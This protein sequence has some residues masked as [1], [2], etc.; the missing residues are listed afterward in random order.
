M[1]YKKSG[2]GKE[3]W[4]KLT[5]AQQD[6]FVRQKELEKSKVYEALELNWYHSKI[7]RVKKILTLVPWSNKRNSFVLLGKVIKNIP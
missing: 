3:W 7:V 6:N 1:A 4:D 2:G 5:I